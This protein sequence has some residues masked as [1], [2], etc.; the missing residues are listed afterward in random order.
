MS[1]FLLNGFVELTKLDIL[2]SNCSPIEP[3][4]SDLFS[5]FPRELL[6]KLHFCSEE[7]AVN[8]DDCSF[9]FIFSKCPVDKRC[10]SGLSRTIDD[11]SVPYQFIFVIYFGGV[12]LS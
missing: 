10:F 5:Y 11:V 12:G 3:A 2:L 1:L 8:H 4:N 6:D 9:T 7:G